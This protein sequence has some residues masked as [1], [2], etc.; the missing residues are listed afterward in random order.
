[1]PAAI[2]DDLELVDIEVTQ[3]VRRLARLGALE[4]ALQ[5]VLEF[6]PVDQTGKQ[7]VAGVIAEAAIELA[8]LA[9]VVEHQHTAGRAASA[10]ANRRCGALHIKLVA[11]AADQQ[12]WPHRF[13]RT[14]APYGDRQRILQRLAGLLV[15]GA[16]NLLNRLAHR[17]FQPPASEIFGNRIDVIDYRGGVG[18]DYTV[19][20]RLQ[21]NLCA[22]LFAEQCFFVELALGDIELDA[23]QSQQAAVRI[24]RGLRPA[25]DPPPFTIAMMHAMHAL[26]HRCFTGDVIANR[27]LYLYRI[28]DMHQGA[29]VKIALQFYSVVAE[30]RPPAR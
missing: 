8:R 12:H 19:A 17:I 7:I 13:D 25:H 20:D 22:L 16:K 21:G 3:R 18:R 10:I 23:H 28:F 24:N 27:V 14:G 6:A 29:P 30:H 26:E 4:R 15:E 11:V 5:P 2:V 9:D 1:M